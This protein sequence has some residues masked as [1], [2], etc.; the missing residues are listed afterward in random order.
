MRELFLNATPSM[1]QRIVDII[2][3]ITD[4]EGTTAK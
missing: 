4:D 1:K 2:D 3:S